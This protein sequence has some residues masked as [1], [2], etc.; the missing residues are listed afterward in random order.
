MSRQQQHNCFNKNTL[1]GPANCKK[2]TRYHAHLSL[3]AKSRKTNNNAKSRKWPKTSVW[4][5]FGDIFTNISKS[6]FFFK[7][8]AL[9]LFY[10]YSPLTLCKKSEKSLELFPSKLLYQPTNQP[11]K[12]QGV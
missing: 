12:Y 6:I 3:Y 1:T 11:T 8:P 9:S 5:I 7:Y 4:A 10:L 2:T